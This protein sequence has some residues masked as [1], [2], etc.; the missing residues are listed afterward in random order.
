MMASR[1][2]F[3]KENETKKYSNFYWTI[4]VVTYYQSTVDAFH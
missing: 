2:I 3:S 4:G 1:F